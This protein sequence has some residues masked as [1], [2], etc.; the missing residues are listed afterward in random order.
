MRFTPSMQ[1]IHQQMGEYKE[2][3]IGRGDE[4]I[5]QTVHKMARI[6]DS[7]AKNPLVREWA[8]C[9]LDGVFVNR[10]MDEAIAIHNFVRDNVRYTRDPSAWEYIQTPPIILAGIKEFIDRKAP[11]PIG[12]CDDMTVLTL[13]LMKSIG[14]PVMVKTVGYGPRFSHVYGMVFINGKWVVS[15]TVR[16]DKYIGWEAPGA[17]RI[18][19]TQA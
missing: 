14:F 10:K 12:D 1:V 17:V 6:I 2:T 16:P 9:I 8:R 11:K 3:D 7:S 19:E 5:E 18:M 13:S 15:D 4:A